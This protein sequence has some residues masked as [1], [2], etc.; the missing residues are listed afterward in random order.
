VPLDFGFARF[1]LN[2]ITQRI[3]LPEI[4]PDPAAPIVLIVR[5]SVNREFSAALF[6]QLQENEAAAKDKPADAPASTAL[7]APTVEDEA[8][9]RRRQAQLYAGTVLVGWERLTD[10]GKPV[11]FSLEVAEELLIQLMTH[12][13]DIWNRRVRDFVNEV[14]NFRPVGAVVDPVDLGKEPPRG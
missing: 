3:E 5:C 13:P 8:A 12:V 11:A 14:K 9:I 1:D 4:S 7:V 6:K 10:G 2:Q